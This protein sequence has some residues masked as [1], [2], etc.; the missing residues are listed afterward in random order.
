M[1]SVTSLCSPCPGTPCMRKCRTK[2]LLNSLGVSPLLALYR[3]GFTII[4]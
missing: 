1:I 2:P 4:W 3:L